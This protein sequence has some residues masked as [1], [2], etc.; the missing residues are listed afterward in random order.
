MSDNGEVGQ[1]H[2][3]FGLPNTTYGGI[4]PQL[5]DRE[6]RQFRLRFLFEELQ[7]LLEGFGYEFDESLWD[8]FRDSKSTHLRE[9]KEDHEQIFDA[10]IDLVYVAHGLSHLLGYPW[11]EGWARVQRANMA[12]QR[13]TRA[14]QSERGGTWDIIKPEGWTPPDIRGLLKAYGW[15]T[16][17]EGQESP[18]PDTHHWDEPNL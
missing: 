16:E 9:P 15:Y 8:I 1:F 13:A 2:H 6:L 18:G 3:K 7:E 14:D 11:R 5:V 4:G 12:K 17:N 10:L